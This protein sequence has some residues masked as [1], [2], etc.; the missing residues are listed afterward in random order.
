[1]RFSPTKILQGLLCTTPIL[2]LTLAACGGGGGGGD[3]PVAASYYS[4]G[5]AVSGVSGSGL[6][7][8][9]NGGNDKA[10]SS[11]DATYTIGSVAAGSSY[12]VTVLTN[13]GS[14]SQL[15]SVA[16][17]SGTMPAFK[18]TNANVSCSTAY[19]VGGVTSSIT[20]L[21][22]TGL[23]LQNNGGDNLLIAA[24][25]TGPFT[26]STPLLNGEPFDVTVLTQPHTPAQTC[27]IGGTTSGNVPG[28]N[29]TVT[30]NCSNNTGSLPLTDQFV[31]VAN[32]GSTGSNGVSPYTSASGVLTPGTMKNAQSAP[33][34]IAVDAGMYAYVTNS[35][36]NTISA[37]SINSVSG[38]LTALTDVDAGTVGNQ[39]S[40][41]TGAGTHPYAIAIHPSGKFAYVTNYSTNSVSAYS[42]GS[43]GALAKIDADGATAGNQTSIAARSG[44][45]SIAIDP[46]GG[47]AYVANANDVLYG[48]SVSVYSINTTTGALTA[49]D[50]DGNGGSSDTYISAGTTSYSVAVDPTGSYLYVA[51][52]GS[53]SVSAFD[54]G[55]NGAGTLSAKGPIS[56]H[57]SNPVAIATHPALQYAYVVNTGNNSVSV[58]S[59][60]SGTL[61][62]QSQA[63][64]G[65]NPSSISIDSTGQYAY[66]TNYGD[67]SVTAYAINQSDGSL[68]TAGISGDPFAT[69]PGPNSVTTAR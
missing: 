26:F 43:D 31:Y 20:G 49:I 22:G 14:P 53:N 28:A 44:P 6:V 7:L 42:I 23:V 65:N 56:D 38:A 57:V 52:E 41:A 40:I 15:C 24:G 9:L 27:T 13:P 51:N 60:S 2:L 46:A 5:G 30:V 34:A 66:V 39:T 61:A 12:N 58:Y 29:V 37:Y 21:T 63:P 62:Y 48:G 47:Y 1:M 54:I 8:R 10:I 4:V 59:I 64:T 16:N 67:N 32:L 11:V 45:I 18:I 3:T 69:G 36:S 33:S 68:S 17:A 50:A 19:T 25:S 35:N 55:N